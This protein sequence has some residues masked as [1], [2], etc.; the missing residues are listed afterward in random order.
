MIR[1]I[2]H[3]WLS[4]FVLFGLI[5][6]SVI[7]VRVGGGVVRTPVDYLFTNPDG[8]PCEM[9][10]LLGVRPGRMSFADAARM[11]R[12]HPMVSWVDDTNCRKQA[13]FCDFEIANL[14]GAHGLILANAGSRDYRVVDIYI[15]LW[16]APKVR[17]GDFFA[18][19]GTPGFMIPH[20][21]CCQSDSLAPYLNR[22]AMNAPTYGVTYYYPDQGV[23]VQDIATLDYG[24]Y[25]LKSEAR[26]RGVRVFQP[27]AVC[28]ATKVYWDVWRGF[29]SLKRLYRYARSLC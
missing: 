8:T 21:A 6:G 17:L 19:L 5:L 24:M 28:D 26:V 14:D 27:Y 10:C 12:Q 22:L 3:A 16:D 11:L 13:G 29:T 7:A 20:F 23:E 25:W 9:P 1:T 2:S 18:E 4:I 15:A